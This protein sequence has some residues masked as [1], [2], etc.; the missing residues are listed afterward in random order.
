MCLKPQ[1]Y[2]FGRSSGF[3]W[4][5]YRSPLPTILSLFFPLSF[6]LFFGQAANPCLEVANNLMDSLRL[7]ELGLL[8]F[9]R[10][11]LGDAFMLYEDG[12]F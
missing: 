7:L 4:T 3:L 2:K 8:A 1:S 10:L 11:H 6:I 5:V 12:E 9:G